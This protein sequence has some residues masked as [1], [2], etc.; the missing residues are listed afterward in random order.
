[1]VEE[2][3]DNP[4]VGRGKEVEGVAEVVVSAPVPE[5]IVFARIAEQ[6]SRISKDAPVTRSPV[7][8][9]VQK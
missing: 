2:Q 7:R 9:A 3:V 1:L 4:V 8:N 5:A 6:N